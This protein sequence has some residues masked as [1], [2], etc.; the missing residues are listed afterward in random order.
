MYNA[1]PHIWNVSSTSHSLLLRREV[2]AP[3]R[4]LEAFCLGT[5]E[6]HLETSF[7][8]HKRTRREI[9]GSRVGRTFHV[10]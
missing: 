5:N 2:V 4:N 9:N 1:I 10:F 7:E 3:D 6:N 8:I